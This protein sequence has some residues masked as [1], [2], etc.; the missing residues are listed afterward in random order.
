MEMLFSLSLPRDALTVPVARHLFASSLGD[1][2]VEEGCIA[3][4]GLVLTEACTNVLRHARGAV[5]DY[6]VQVRIVNG[7]AVIKV[8]DTEGSFDPP[9][10]GFDSASE[11]AEGG[12]GLGLMHVLVDELDFISSPNGGTVVQLTKELELK[13]DS[14]LR[15]IEERTSGA[16]AF[17]T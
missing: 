6:Q 10:Q 2:G 13:P 16:G 12:R 14:V 11:T 9:A 8:G 17:R 3:D 5:G 4:L 7:E 1:L 15:R